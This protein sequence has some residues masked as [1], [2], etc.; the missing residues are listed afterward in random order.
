M[1][2]SII[3]VKLDLR[4]AERSLWLLSLRIINL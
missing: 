3:Y 2:L 1:T 4:E